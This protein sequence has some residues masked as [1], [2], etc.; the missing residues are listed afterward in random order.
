MRRW[1]LRWVVGLALVPVACG[2]MR[3]GPTQTVRIATIPPGARLTVDGE[4]LRSPGRL[5]LERDR[6]YE[7]RASMDG[8]EPARRRIRSRP[9]RG[10][11]VLNCAF[12]LC[13]PQLWEGGTAVQR[14]L[15]PDEVEI[16]LNPKGWSPR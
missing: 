6:D 14:R 3:N 5:E 10:V 8:F 9:D 13:I 16:M 7:V 11:K 4:T 1:L 12:F 15:V 2:G